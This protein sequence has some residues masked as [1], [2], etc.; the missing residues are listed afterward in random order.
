MQRSMA[1]KFQ[2]LRASQILVVIIGGA[3]I[4][5][6]ML[7]EIAI[8]AP[9]RR[10][11]T[12]ESDKPLDP[13][14]RV[15]VP[16]RSREKVGIVWAEASEV[17]K[18]LRS[19]SRSLDEE[20]LFDETAR[21][22]YE[23]AARYYGIPLGELLTSALPKKLKDGKA[24]ESFD[25]KD[26]H[27]ELV[28]L[29]AKQKEV[30]DNF[31]LGEGFYS[32]LLLGET[33]SGKTEVYLELMSQVLAAGGQVLFLVPEISLTPQLEDR[34]SERL[35]APVSPF[36]SGL[37]ESLRF[38]T[39]C[40]AQEGSP[41]VFLGAR[42]ALFLPFKNLKLII[43]DEEHDSSYKQSERGP[44]HA[45]DLALLRANLLRIPVL[46]GSATPSLETYQRAIDKKSGLRRLKKF[47]EGQKAN[48]QI[49]DLKKT[50]ETEEKSFISSAIQQM[51][52]SRIERGEQVLLFL[53]RRGSASQRV[54]TQ[55][56]S[57]DHCK[58]CSSQLTLHFDQRM[59]ICHLCGYQTPLTKDCS[60]CGSKEFF[61]GGV[62]TKEV[63]VQISERFPEAR[64][65]RLD[66]DKVSKKN[67]L[68]ET[69]RDFAQGKIDILV[70]TQMISKGIDIPKL[71]GIGVVLADQGWGVPDFRAMEKSFQLLHQILGR[72]GRRG[73]SV[74]CIIQTFSPQHPVF[75]YLTKDE[76][77]ED[78]AS[79][80]LELRKTAGLPP[81][82]K[83]SL[84]TFADRDEA[85]TKKAASN[86]MHRTA[87]LSKH[88]GVELMGPVEA[89]IYR[90]KSD[91]RFQVIAKT[92]EIGSMS[93]FIQLVL[94]D[95]DERPY[96]VRVKLD[97]D[98]LHFL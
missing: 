74:D 5:E 73:Q 16:F 10:L 97:R 70:G 95:M 54:C 50:W 32:E 26:F 67:I 71:T 66:R 45:R 61:I 57:I 43:I 31:Q 60:S 90:W 37:K 49:V 41:D 75:S 59:A 27:P 85:R 69:L 82:S 1:S 79:S 14:S 21:Q 17:P 51:V 65:A 53:N 86:F 25:K 91:Y 38:E 39:F 93:S 88:L 22:F 98:P 3:L 29:T 23:T 84:W 83:L 40:R 24:L 78:F 92:Q 42:S 33:G 64:V 81:F 47:H 48:I 80:E 96:E 18:G 19:V 62:G 56:G 9:L 35:G 46:L 36:H 89:P 30:V 44:Y 12:Y 7:Y 20:P 6:W 72:G 77:F 34:L 68:S 52:H 87:E 28:E 15:Q 13:G 58:F 76:A 4:K 63:E 94:D 11:F 2:C 8:K 55:C